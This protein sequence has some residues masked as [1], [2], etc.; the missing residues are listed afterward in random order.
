MDQIAQL[1]SWECLKNGTKLFKRLIGVRNLS[2]IN[3][4]NF[5]KNK[6]SKFLVNCFTKK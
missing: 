1:Y 4:L 5:F 3:D 2:T 6:S